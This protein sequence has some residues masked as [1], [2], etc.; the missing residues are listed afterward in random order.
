M[1]TRCTLASIP[2]YVICTYIHKYTHTYVQ[3]FK[4]LV[5]TV[6]EKPSPKITSKPRNVTIAVG[7]S[8]TFRC[9]VEG[10]PNHYWVGWMTKNTI[11][12]PGEEYSVSTSPSFKSTNGTT[13][14][15]TVHTIKEAGKYDCQVYSLTGDVVDFITHEVIISNGMDNYVYL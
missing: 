12:Q 2:T 3:C 13:H 10:D 14:Y 4:Y 5:H 15:L 8:I 11:I 7:L 6:T 1:H 9:Y